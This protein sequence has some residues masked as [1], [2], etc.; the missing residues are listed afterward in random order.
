MRRAA[1]V[2]LAGVAGAI[3]T[4][5]AGCGRPAER[6]V[7]GPG[8][9]RGA[10]VLLVTIDTLRKD[11]VGAYGNGSGL[12]PNLDRLAVNGVRYAQA[13]SPVPMTLPAHASIFTGLLPRRHGIR[14]NTGFRLDEK[15][16]TLATRLKEA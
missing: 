3:A 11:R 7:A 14:N 8:A 13:F 9:L 4:A 10:N 12:T 16:P 15:I 2:L 6:A 1:A 5:A